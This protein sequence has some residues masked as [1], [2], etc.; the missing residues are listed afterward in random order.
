VDWHALRVDCLTDTYY[1]YVERSFSPFIRFLFEN[2]YIL[3]SDI[4]LAP[5]EYVQCQDGSRDVKINVQRLDDIMN[6]YG[7]I[8]P[9][10]DLM[11]DIDCVRREMDD[12]FTKYISFNTKE[13]YDYLLGNYYFHKIEPMM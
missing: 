9:S 13:L 3:T 1:D 4:A 12:L 11:L 2:F 5:C 7:F 6:E 8:Y 10:G